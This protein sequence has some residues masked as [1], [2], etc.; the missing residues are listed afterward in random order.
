MN[1]TKKE[2]IVPVK[3]IE[4]FQRGQI[5]ILTIVL[6]VLILIYIEIDCMMLFSHANIVKLVAIVA[7]PLAIVTELMVYKI[8]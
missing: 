5:R 4:E 1:R 3:L 7:E 6:I 2:A 8:Y